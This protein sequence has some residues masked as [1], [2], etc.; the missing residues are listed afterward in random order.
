MLEEMITEAKGY[1]NLAGESA[2]MMEIYRVIEEV[3]KNDC[4]VMI[5]GETSTGKDLVA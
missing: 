4:T 2:E 3:A 1:G 5:T